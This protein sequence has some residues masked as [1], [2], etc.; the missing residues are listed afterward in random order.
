M[1]IYVSRSTAV[2]SFSLSARHPPLSQRQ[3]SRTTEYRLDRDGTGSELED[4]FDLVI[5]LS[6]P[7]DLRLQRIE[8]REISLFGCADPAFMAW[9]AQYEQGQLPGRSRARHEAWLKSRRCRV[10]RFEQDQAIEDRVQEI[11]ELI[12]PAV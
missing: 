11:I 4:A 9:S 6:L 10:L 5:F 12:S 7:T 2:H 8:A 1:S 3:I